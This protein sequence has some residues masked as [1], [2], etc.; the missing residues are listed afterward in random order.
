M[1]FRDIA[2]ALEMAAGTTRA[3]FGDTDAW[4][5]SIRRFQGQDTVSPPAAGGVVFIGGSSSP[6]GPRSN[7]TWPRC[8]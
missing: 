7:K 1:T 2:K 5:G 3:A 6:S 8:P 4:E